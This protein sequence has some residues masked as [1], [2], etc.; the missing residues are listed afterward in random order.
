MKSSD[1][2]LETKGIKSTLIFEIIG[3]PP[4]NLIKV[5]E[6]IIK[7]IDEENGVEVKSRNIKEPILMKDQKDLYTTFAEVDVEVEQIQHIAILMFKYMPAH[8]EVVSPE[9]ITLT[10]N[11]WTDILSELTR[12][13]HAYDEVA[14]VLRFQNAQM[15]EKLKKLEPEKKEEKSKKK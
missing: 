7:R 8:V 1:K 5:L 2:S 11:G 13:L 12:R 6:T 14:R 3:R 9:L 4:E 15:Q 10:N